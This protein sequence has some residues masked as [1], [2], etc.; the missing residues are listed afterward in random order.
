M[1]LKGDW[2]KKKRHWER[3][4]SDID[5]GDSQ[6]CESEE[7]SNTMGYFFGE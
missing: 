7:V 6:V 2:M 3:S 4:L 1:P 5:I